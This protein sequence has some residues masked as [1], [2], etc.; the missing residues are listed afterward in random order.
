MMLESEIIL[1]N[2]PTTPAGVMD[3]QYAHARQ[4]KLHLQFRLK[5]RAEVVVRSVRRYCSSEPVHLLEVG[6]ADGHTLEV[7]AQS[8]GKGEFVGVEYND[9]LRGTQSN[10]SS[11]IRLIK[12]DAMSLPAEI[13]DESFDVVS[14]L[15][16]LEHL[17]DP[18]RALAEAMR[19]LKPGAIVVASCPNPT[20]DRVAGKLGMV[21]DDYHMT[22]IDL[23]CLQQM[24]ISVGFH[25]QNARRF[26]WAPVAVLPYAKIPVPIHWAYWID[27][28]IDVIP[29]IR[30]L[31]VNACVVGMKPA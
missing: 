6:A 28:V 31:C 14:M 25:V 9:E 30:K 17:P 22:Q 8:L 11:D 23:R 10:L 4:R 3:V 27:R 29:L 2:Q 26:M 13:E 16:L 18:N 5:M 24:M 7:I 21:D 1:T 20:W 15:A 19:V 12:G